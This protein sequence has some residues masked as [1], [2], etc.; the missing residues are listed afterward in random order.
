MLN[1]R[2]IDKLLLRLLVYLVVKENT[3]EKGAEAPWFVGLQG[4]FLP[5][6]AQAASLN[7]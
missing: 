7:S 3:I 1:N 5:R 2:I 4:L 6:Q